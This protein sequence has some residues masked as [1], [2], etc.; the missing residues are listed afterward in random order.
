MSCYASSGTCVVLL[1]EADPVP[2]LF[3]RATVR[4]EEVR[5]ARFRL[6]EGAAS[7]LG[8]GLHRA[9]F[10][11]LEERACGLLG[12]NRAGLFLLDRAP[13]RLLEE[14]APGCNWGLNCGLT[15]Q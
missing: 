6:E 9:A 15:F 4:F 11:F 14:W 12:E 1:S 10:A 2:Y 8:L 3:E 5:A 7:G 13:F